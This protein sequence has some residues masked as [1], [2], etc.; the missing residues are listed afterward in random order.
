VRYPLKQQQKRP[1]SVD[2]VDVLLRTRVHNRPSPHFSTFLSR[3]KGGIFFLKRHVFCPLCYNHLTPMSPRHILFHLILTLFLNFFFF[4]EIRGLGSAL[5]LLGLQ[6]FLISY[7]WTHAKAIWRSLAVS[8]AALL[9][10]A[11]LLTLR[12]SEVAQSILFLGGSITVLASFY[13]LTLKQE[14]FQSLSELT[15]FLPRT[16]LSYFKSAKPSFIA[17][18]AHHQ[19]QQQSGAQTIASKINSIAVGLAL[20]IPVLFILVGLLSGADPIFGS[21]IQQLFDGTAL[22]TTAQHIVLSI[23]ILAALIPAAGIRYPHFK[24]PGHTIREKQFATEFSV[25]QALVALVLA[26]FV[27]IQWQ[28]IFIPS[29]SGVDLSQFGF[30]TYSEYVQRGFTEFIFVSIV[31]FTLLWLGLLFWQGTKNRVLYFFQLVVASEFLI[32]LAS[33]FRRIW[34]YQEYHGM[35]LIRF[36]GAFLMIALSFFVLTLLARHF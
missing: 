11:V 14:H 9:Y 7:F 15:L 4:Q 19:K 32:L 6:I 1:M 34:L 16:V 8:T 22:Q 5:L 13:L 10:F 28:Y 12:S 23:V 33:F 3:T 18:V 31:L 29:V 25:V 36:Y 2:D 20:S 24:N 27:M 35:T 21:S 17:H 30:S 26:F